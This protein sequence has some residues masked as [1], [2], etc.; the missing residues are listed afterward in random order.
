MRLPL[1][2]FQCQLL[3]K[4]SLG[5]RDT[6]TCAQD[7]DVAGHTD[8]Q[9]ESVAFSSVCIQDSHKTQSQAAKSLPPLMLAEAEGH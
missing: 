7:T 3:S 5:S 9:R 4:L 1:L 6:H 8:C 2:P